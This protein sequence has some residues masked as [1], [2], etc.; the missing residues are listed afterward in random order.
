VLNRLLV[1]SV[2]LRYPPEFAPTDIEKRARYEALTFIVH[3]MAGF[4]LFGAV[5]FR[6][7]G[8]IIEPS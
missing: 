1:R 4:M 3:V 6:I 8:F 2:R 5:I 7:Y